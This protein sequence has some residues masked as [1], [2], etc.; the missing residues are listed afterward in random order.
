MVAKVSKESNKYR[1]PSKG[2]RVRKGRLGLFSSRRS[3]APADRFGI[4]V[5]YVC[6]GSPPLPPSRPYSSKRA[7][8][9]VDNRTR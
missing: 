2:K 9:R 3:R 4:F 1:R 7:F 6:A 8:F 5:G